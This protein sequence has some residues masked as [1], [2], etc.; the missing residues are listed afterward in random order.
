MNDIRPE[1]EPDGESILSQEEKTELGEHAERLYNK[2]VQI[3][4]GA[5]RG[6]FWRYD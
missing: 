4:E 3:M 2:A 5:I 6:V 1:L